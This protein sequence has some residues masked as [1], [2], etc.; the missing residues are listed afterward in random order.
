MDQTCVYRILHKTPITPDRDAR[1]ATPIGFLENVVD[2]Y[3]NLL[4]K[5][6]CIQRWQKKINSLCNECRQYEHVVV[7][8]NSHSSRKLCLNCYTGC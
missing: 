2:V 8:G 1:G 5:R 3:S 7:L 6:D 4:V